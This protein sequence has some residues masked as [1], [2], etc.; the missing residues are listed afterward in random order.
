MTLPGTGKIQ[1]T[2]K[3]GEVMQESTRAALSY[4]RSMSD[5]LNID[6][7]WYNKNDIHIHVPEGATPK[8]G[9]SAG[10]TMATALASAITG[11]PVKQTVAMTGEITLR[12]RVIIPAKN[13]KDLIKIPSEI[14]SGMTIIACT[15]A[16]EVLRVA[17][18]HGRENF[19]KV[20][21]FQVIDGDA[22]VTKVAN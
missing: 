14:K 13:E 5:R 4:I 6:H 7:D 17:L 10:I 15:E 8:D 20:V 3:L 18:D 11:I 9:P 19:M 2:G 16:D 1:I 12:G 22:G 21:N